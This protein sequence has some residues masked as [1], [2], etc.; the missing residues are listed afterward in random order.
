MQLTSFKRISNLIR[1]Q[2]NKS[3]IHFTM[4]SVELF[5][6]FTEIFQ[7]DKPLVH[8]LYLKLEELLKN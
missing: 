1:K 2:T 3:K 5:M 8:V 4:P 7:K 6:S